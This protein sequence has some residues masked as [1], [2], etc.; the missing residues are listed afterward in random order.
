V[1]ELPD[2][3]TKRMVDGPRCWNQPTRHAAAIFS[4]PVRKFASHSSSWRCWLKTLPMYSRAGGS[5][6]FL[7]AAPIMTGFLCGLQSRLELGKAD[8]KPIHSRKWLSV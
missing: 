4:S 7:L 6:K 3:L 8:A 1:T 5:G 2:Y